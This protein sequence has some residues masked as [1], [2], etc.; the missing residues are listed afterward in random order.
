MVEDSTAAGYAILAI[1]VSGPGGKGTLNVVSNRASSGWEIQRGVLHKAAAQKAAPEIIDLT[2]ATRPDFFRYPTLG[3]T[4]LLPLDARAAADVKDLPTYYGTRLGLDVQLLPVQQLGPEVM[5]ANATQVIAEK[6]LVS[7]ARSQP[8]M[9]DDL[10]SVLLAVTSQDMNFQS[11]NL[12]YANN[13]RSGRFSIV[14]TARFHA[15]PWYVGANQEAFAV[16]ARKLVTRDIALMRYPLDLSPDVTSALTRDAYTLPELD[17][18]GESFAGQDGNAGLVSQGFPCVTIFQGSAGK[19]GLRVGC[20]NDAQGDARFER[21]ETHPDIPLFVMSHADFYFPEEPSFPFLRKYRPQDDRSRPFGIGASDSFDVF[22]VGD[23]QTFAW[24]ELI[25][26]D[27]DRVHYARTSPGS[28]FSNAELR[29]RAELGNRFSLSTMHWNGDG[30]DI[31]TREGW[32]YAFPSSGPEKTWQQGALTGL[33]SAWG[34]TF[35][36]RRTADSDLQELR[37]PGGGSIQFTNDAQHRITAAKESTGRTVQYNYDEA[38]RLVHVVGAQNGDEF[39]EYDPAN[40]LTVVRDAQHRALLIN[41]YG[42]LGEMLSQTLADGTKLLYENGFD[43]N[44]KLTSL[45]LTL[46]NGYV[47]FWQKTR[48]GL[49]RSWPQ[50]PDHAVADTHP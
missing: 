22:P 4:Y 49:V 2:P 9:G 3:H 12:R 30:W 15:T 43:E 36:I 8:E 20:T 10:N 25:M 7:V 32:T 40:R 34:K 16:R 39:Y 17:R 37:T 50:A 29:A 24:I 44:H 21:F 19:Q 14:S 23:S 26:A 42:Y 31:L 47:I 28:D 33:H 5:N 41:K 48:N 38:G 27:G 46:P 11:L 6:A 1:P 35:S 45:K 13:M 18:M